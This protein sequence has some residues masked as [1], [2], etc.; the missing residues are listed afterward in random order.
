[1]KYDVTDKLPE[2][3]NF[4][5]PRRSARIASQQ[6]VKHA[7][8]SNASG[9]GLNL[10][11]RF[12]TPPPRALKGTK[13]GPSGGRKSHP[14]PGTRSADTGGLPNK[15]P[16]VSVTNDPRT[17]TEELER[18]LTFW[19]EESQRVQGDVVSYEVKSYDSLNDDDAVLA[20]ASVWLPLINWGTNFAF[21]EATL[22]QTNRL[23]NSVGPRCVLSPNPFVMP[24]IFSRGV[25]NPPEERQEYHKRRPSPKPAGEL[26]KARKIE[27]RE[28]YGR[29][30]DAVN[31]TLKTSILTKMRPKTE[32]EK[33]NLEEK[34][35]AW[36]V[37]EGINYGHFTL[38]VAERV[39]Y[40]TDSVR[41]K[42]WD[43][44]PGHVSRDLIRGTARN[45]VRNCHWMPSSV[46]PRFVEEEEHWL[47]S[48]QQSGHSC[49]LH[50]VLNAWAYMLNISVN[51][52]APVLRGEFYDDALVIIN[53]ALQGCMDARTI[54]AFFHHHGYA[55]PRSFR[56]VSEME[57][58]TRPDQPGDMR[59]LPQT[60][61]MNENIL[62]HAISRLE[63]LGARQSAARDAAARDSAARDSHRLVPPRAPD[64][65]DPT[66]DPTAGIQTLEKSSPPNSGAPAAPGSFNTWE[67]LLKDGLKQARQKAEESG[68]TDYFSIRKNE[69]NALDDDEVGFAIASIW[70][71]LRRDIGKEFGFGTPNTFQM[72]RTAANR[73]AGQMA[74]GNMRPL[75]I[76]LFLSD[77][78][79]L[80]KP[81]KK[82]EKGGKK[83][84]KG[85]EVGGVGH[86]ILA[87]AERTNS[88]VTLT[89]MDSRP[90][91][92]SASEITA[93]AE[94]IVTYSGWMG[95]TATGTPIA[96]TPIF[97][98][99]V[100]QQ[101]PHQTGWNNCGF[102][103]V[104]NAWAYMLSIPIEASGQ[105]RRT[106]A[107]IRDSHGAEF[108][109]LGK[110]IMNLALRGAMDSRTI[111]A[112]L[113][114]YGYAR[115]QD[116]NSEN[117]YPLL[118]NAAE[119]SSA[120]LQ[121]VMTELRDEQQ[122]SA[123][124]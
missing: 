56:D 51:Q 91:T 39:P 28:A 71:G 63:T 50:V 106:A 93:A 120:I 100:I 105:R 92:R 30:V 103:V 57:A 96:S 13:A 31:K 118:A 4:G 2:P 109:R 72:H 77:K 64:P 18:R 89:F 52:K 97:T 85:G 61:R 46:W 84:G 40:T 119:M 69:N 45:L 108:Y 90:G 11:K 67:Q 110:E 20:I 76:P 95:V 37:Q 44:S 68:R 33:K 14:R 116:I 99:Q 113:N 47:R 59:H 102:H 48:P 15:P 117:D 34:K 112:F 79:H 123:L 58:S 75:I 22:F 24:L 35:K 43:S 12:P 121:E 26:E 21:G 7:V 78:E 83:G 115:A 27:E 5:A 49:G 8:S 101:V 88:D 54:R 16:V 55:A 42:F 111:Q 9:I 53:L 32:G 94:G 25:D 86:F 17:W 82:P 65:P 6:A 124:E 80:P 98:P 10:P 66:P 23:D 122:I 3:S 104:L 1:M 38:A 114:V 73:D 70:L 107:C 81:N 60:A 29:H 87:V 62:K 41:L 74:V 19:K 36:R